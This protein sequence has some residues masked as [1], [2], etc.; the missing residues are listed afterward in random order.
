MRIISVMDKVAAR[1]VLG[2]AK[3]KQ[4]GVAYTDVHL[5]FCRDKSL[6][7]DKE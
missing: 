2:T 4:G 6:L 3:T 5:F 7:C 1:D